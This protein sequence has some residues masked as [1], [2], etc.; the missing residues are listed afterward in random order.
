LYDPL[1]FAFDGVVVANKVLD[2]AQLGISEVLHAHRGLNLG[3]IQDGFAGL[4]A[5]PENISQGHL[6][7]LVI[8]DG[9]TGNSGHR[10][11]LPLLMFRLHLID[12]VNA[13]FAAHNLIIGTDFFDTGTDFH[14][15]HLLSA[16]DTLLKLIFAVSYPTLRQIVRSQFYLNAVPWN[17]TDVVFPHPSGDVSY[18]LMAVFEFN[19][20]LGAWQRLFD[21]TRQ[22]NDLFLLRHKYNEVIVAN[23]TRVCKELLFA[24]FI[25]FHEPP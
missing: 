9:H 18:D 12:D 6:D 7:L 25:F 15:D 23:S 13:A 8:G 3:F 2:A 4:G 10:L 11:T 17:E 24:T 5:N 16:G 19:L 1:Q 20:E 14:P 22:L 21:G